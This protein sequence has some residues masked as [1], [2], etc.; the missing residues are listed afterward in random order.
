[1]FMWQDISTAPKD[2]T[3]IILCVAG[4]LPDGSYVAYEP[5]CGQWF[6]D[7][8]VSFDPE[9]VFESDDALNDYLGGTQYNPTVWMPMPR[10]PVDPRED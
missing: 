8:W 9:G 3:R 5:C 4:Y 7:Q 2:G 6:R 10:P 1:M